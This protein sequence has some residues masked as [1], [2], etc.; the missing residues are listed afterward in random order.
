VVDRKVDHEEHT[1]VVEGSG[2]GFEIVG[3]TKVLVDAEL[4]DTPVPL[5]R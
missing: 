2:E 3:G 1:P 5:F 4:V